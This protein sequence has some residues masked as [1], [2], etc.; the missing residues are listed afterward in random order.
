MLCC[1]AFGVIPPVAR[2][3]PD[4]AKYYFIS[5]YTAKVAGTEMGIKEPQATFSPCFGGPFLVHHPVVYAD[6]LAKKMISSNAT[7]YLINTGWV[8]GAY[9][10]GKRCPIK[11][12]RKICDAINEGT[13]KTAKTR[14]MP[15]FD[16]DVIE[17]IPD[18]PSDIMWPE[19]GWKD[20]AAFN[21]TCNKLAN[22]FLANF[23]NFGSKATPDILK[24]APKPTEIMQ[25]TFATEG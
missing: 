9:G 19:S 3:T 16:F 11:V 20:K 8:G 12:T 10:V 14:K 18:V 23:K 15:I 13:L 7:V 24:A 2:L 21:N 6:L 25:V 17:S 1:D 22:M 4:Q 5:G